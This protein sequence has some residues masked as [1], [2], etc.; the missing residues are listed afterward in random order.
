MLLVLFLIT[1]TCFLITGCGF[2]PLYGDSASG[3]MQSR[4]N[5][6]EIGSIPDHQGLY[7]RNQLIDR[8]YRHG[9]PADP[10]YSLQFT[11]LIISKTDLDLT[12]N[13]SATR[14]QLSASTTMTLTDKK[15]GQ[16]VLSR[17]LY[18][19]A[20]YNILD[21]RFTTRVSESNAEENALTDLARQAEQQILL[22]FH[23]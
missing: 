6:V 18:S 22:Y 17:S 19:S 4:L 12:K 21:S 9:A 10:A 14:S 15:T 1:D 20:S 8:F 13:A 3:P 7:L 16:T 23:R 2:T 11:P 5:A